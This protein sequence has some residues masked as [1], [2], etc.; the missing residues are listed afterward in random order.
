MGLDYKMAT[1]KCPYCKK[2][3]AYLTLV[4]EYRCPNCD[5]KINLMN[6]ENKLKKMAGF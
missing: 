5:G 3:K 4:G 6:V 2:G 1:I